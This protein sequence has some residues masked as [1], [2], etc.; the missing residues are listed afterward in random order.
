[1]IGSN[2]INGSGGLA[3][4]SGGQAIV[5]C[6]MET[7]TMG[8]NI[9]T[10]TTNATDKSLPPNSTNENS[11]SLTVMEG[12]LKHRI[13]SICSSDRRKRRKKRRKAGNLERPFCLKA[14][15][16]N[17]ST[18]CHQTSLHGWQYIAQKHTSTPKHIFWAVIV[19]L[20]M[21]TAALFLYNNTVDYLNATVRSFA[22]FL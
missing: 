15:M 13:S 20:S 22:Y 14:T 21:A 5:P 1:M 19:S 9:L 18:F 12:G 8:N 10:T 16:K 3:P 4:G 17:F 11:T 2:S 7:K 6:Q